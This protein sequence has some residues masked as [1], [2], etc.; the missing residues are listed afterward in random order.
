VIA[1]AER[2][3]RVESPSSDE[4]HKYREIGGFFAG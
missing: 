3:F 2:I 4:A 1:S